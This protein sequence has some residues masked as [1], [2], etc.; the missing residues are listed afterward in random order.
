[1]NNISGTWVPQTVTESHSNVQITA[2]PPAHFYAAEQNVV[3]H[4]DIG[5]HVEEPYNGS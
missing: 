1:M 3:D 4:I 5:M 2:C